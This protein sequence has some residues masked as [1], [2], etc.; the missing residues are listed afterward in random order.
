MLTLFSIAAKK[1]IWFVHDKYLQRAFQITVDNPDHF[2]QLGNLEQ[3][4]TCFSAVMFF[5]HMPSAI[6]DLLNT[7]QYVLQFIMV[8]VGASKFSK[9]NNLQ[10]HQ[11]IKAMMQKVKNL[12]KV[13]GTHHSDGFKG[14]L[15]SLMI[16]V[17]WY[18]G[19]QQQKAARSKIKA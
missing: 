14:I 12:V 10:Q 15:Y 13:M 3:V 9:Y 7:L 2:H 6:L 17:P 1:A 4:E 19:W 5:D 16:L 11:N 18:P 8:H